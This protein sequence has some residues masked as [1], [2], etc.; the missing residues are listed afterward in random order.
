MRRLLL[1]A[2]VLVALGL[3]ALPAFANPNGS[4]L[5]PTINSASVTI[6]P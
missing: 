5:P 3:L 4:I 1:A 6:T 2:L